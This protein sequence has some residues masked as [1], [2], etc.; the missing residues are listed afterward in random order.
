MLQ[1]KNRLVKKKDFASLY[2]KGTFCRLEKGDLVIRFLKNKVKAVRI[3]FVVGKNYSKKAT[4]RNAAKRL[5]RAA[6]Y[7]NIGLIKPGYDIIVHYSKNKQQAKSLEYKELMLQI[8]KAIK[9][10]K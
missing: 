3:G 4:E 9:K 2:Q 7:Q 6:F 1:K 5:L 10:I 8:K